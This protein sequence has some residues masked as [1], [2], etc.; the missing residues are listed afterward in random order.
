MFITAQWLRAPKDG[1]R[2]V[3]VT[4]YKHPDGVPHG[5]DVKQI[6]DDPLPKSGIV[7]YDELRRGGNRVQAQVDLV[8]DDKDFDRETI[9]DALHECERT[10]VDV[11]VSTPL[12]L[13]VPLKHGRIHGRFE[14][15][16][17]P[18]DPQSARAVFYIL[19]G[20]IDTALAKHY[21]HLAA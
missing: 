11:Y 6:A 10:Q 2:G 1:T 18:M 3:N 7:R 9:R 15:L 16:T 14:I 5:G 12:A 21:V 8:L 17:G 20:A 13:D 4:I 19:R